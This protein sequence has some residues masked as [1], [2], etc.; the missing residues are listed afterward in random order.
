MEHYVDTWQLFAQNEDSL[1]RTSAVGATA[2]LSPE[3]PLIADAAPQQNTSTSE[4]ASF[5]ER[6][7]ISAFT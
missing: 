7:N 6:L 5:A 3:S 1:F 2:D 4:A